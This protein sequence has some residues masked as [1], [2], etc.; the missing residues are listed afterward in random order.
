L[1]AAKLASAPGTS[2]VR[3]LDLLNSVVS[4]LL[5]RCDGSTFCPPPGSSRE[6]FMLLG[7]SGPFWTREYPWLGEAALCSRVQEVLLSVGAQQ[8]VVGH[9]PQVR[10]LMR[11]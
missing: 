10:A 4:A 9:T 7:E 5:D 3:P 11:S 6:A 8:V 2:S 1:Q